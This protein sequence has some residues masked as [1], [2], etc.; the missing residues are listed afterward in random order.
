[1]KIREVIGDTVYKTGTR[2]MQLAGIGTKISV[3][4]GLDPEMD[5]RM[6]T[7]ILERERCANCA[8]VA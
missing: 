2:D 7:M 6:L 8:E 3:A 4:L 5:V 1:M